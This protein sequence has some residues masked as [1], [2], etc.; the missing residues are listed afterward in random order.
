MER[1]AAISAG[2]FVTTFET[3]ARAAEQQGTRCHQLAS[4]SSARCGS[5][6]LKC[7]GHHDGDR[8]AGVALFKGAILRAGGT[9]HIGDTPGRALGQDAMVGASWSAMSG[10]A[11]QG[12]V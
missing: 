4:G 9:H 1:Q 12:L 6:I 8:E 7:P 3:L 2:V 10:A 5:A 11:S